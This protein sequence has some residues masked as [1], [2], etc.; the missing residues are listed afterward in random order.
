[1]SCIVCIVEQVAFC[2]TCGADQLK[3]TGT[4]VPRLHQA[5][6]TKDLLT[7]EHCP[8]TAA[9]LITCGVWSLW[10]GGNARDRG[11]Q[12]WTTTVAARHVSSMLEDFICSGP[13][14]SSTSRL[15]QDAREMATA[16]PWVGKNSHR[17]CLHCR[18]WDWVYRCNAER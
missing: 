12:S 18:E 9:K 17:C 15:Q 7:S 13:A 11:K 1:V 6:W 5:T 2:S 3:L 4:T 10:T 8:E 14:A 16:S